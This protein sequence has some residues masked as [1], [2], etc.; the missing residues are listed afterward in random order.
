[1][2]ESIVLYTRENC[3]Q[4]KIA[5]ISCTRE[6]EPDSLVSTFCVTQTVLQTDLSVFTKTSSVQVITHPNLG[7]KSHVN[8]RGQGLSLILM[9]VSYAV[10]K[11]AT[12]TTLQQMQYD[13]CT[14]SSALS[15]VISATHKILG[16]QD[17]NVYSIVRTTIEP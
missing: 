2:I 17:L 8:F 6:Q 5:F 11:S 12:L 4:D 3:S 10:Q 14:Q 9:H 7:T 16:Q 13:I 15:V 1:M